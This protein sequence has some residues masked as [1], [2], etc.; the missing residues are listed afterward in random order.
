MPNVATLDPSFGRDLKFS[1]TRCGAC[2][3]HVGSGIGLREKDQVRLSGIE[4]QKNKV[5]HP[6][7]GE[8]IQSSADGVCSALTGSADCTVYLQRPLVCRLYPFYLSIGGDGSL[9]LSVDHCPGVNRSEGATIDQDYISR[10]ILP[11]L[12]E[13]SK[14]VSTLKEQILAFKE[15]S[16]VLTELG[17]RINWRARKSLWKQLSES[18][19]STLEADF[20][21]RDALEVLKVDV[22]PFMERSFDLAYDDAVLSE[23]DIEEFFARYGPSIACIIS[24]S[25]KVQK[26]HRTEIQRAGAIFSPSGSGDDGMTAFSSR[27]GQSFSV[28]SKD[29]L[30]MRQL[31]RGAIATELDYLMEV[32]R[33]EFVYAGVMVKP[34]TLEQESS[35]LF[36]LADAIELGAN[37]LAIHKGAEVLDSGLVNQSICEVDASILKTVRALGGELAISLEQESD[38]KD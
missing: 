10:E 35:L 31:D 24:D 29:L 22:V 9:Q 34:L 19:M 28:S 26:L 23:N 3:R 16:Y 5:R 38:A 13:D 12:L 1:C 20:S 8:S 27:T 7:F 14:F 25:I 32:V 6:I 18:V 37:A 4:I 30:K 33:R 11:F 17:V 21:P 15:D 2:C 36:L